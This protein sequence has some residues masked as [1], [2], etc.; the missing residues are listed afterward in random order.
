[1]GAE[2]LVGMP[3]A[4]GGMVVKGGVLVV[5]PGCLGMGIISKPRDEGRH[6][7]DGERSRA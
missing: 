6:S 4:R 3:A 2:L 5:F 1:M 7:C